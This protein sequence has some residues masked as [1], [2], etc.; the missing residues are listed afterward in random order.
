MSGC[1]FPSESRWA[2]ILNHACRLERHLSHSKL[3]MPAALCKAAGSW[4]DRSLE[5]GRALARP[6]T[7]L[8]NVNEIYESEAK[9][10]RR[11]QARG[12]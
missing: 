4:A 2:L 1:T 3:Q 11:V 5:D 8:Q 12:G 10:T 7:D 6:C 9:P